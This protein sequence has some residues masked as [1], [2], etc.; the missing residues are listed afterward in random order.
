MNVTLSPGMQQF[1]ERKLRAGE[2]QSPEQVVEAGLAVLQQQESTKDF[3]PGELERL[4]AAGQADI[5]AGKV[6]DG[7]EV[8][9]EIADLSV[10]RRQRK[11][12]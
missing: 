4:I 1:I 2:Y 3:A 5:D 7:D 10:L 6:Y 9:R 8:F 11:L 12:G